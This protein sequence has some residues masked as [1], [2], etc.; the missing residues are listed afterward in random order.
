[1]T[2]QV[3]MQVLEE[4][5]V[6]YGQC[7]PPSHP[8]FPLECFQGVGR[9]LYWANVG[10]TGRHLGTCGQAV[11]IGSV[12]RKRDGRRWKSATRQGRKQLGVRPRSLDHLWSLV[13]S[14]SD[15]KYCTPESS[16]RHT[17]RLKCLHETCIQS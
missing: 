3:M 11:V 8:G 2:P 13:S 14:T 9:G 7:W 12:G 1:M 6:K 10:K 15:G 16:H 5:I 4:S 17:I